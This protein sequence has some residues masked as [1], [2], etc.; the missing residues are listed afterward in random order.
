MAIM[1]SFAGAVFKVGIESYR[2]SGANAEIMRN[3]RAITDQLNADFQGLQKD[4]P[5]TIWFE[6]DPVS[7][8]RYDQIQ[9]FAD[10]DFQTTKL[11]DTDGDIVTPPDSIIYGNIAS[12]YYGHGWVVDSAMDA[13]KGYRVLDLNG[14]GT[15][16]AQSN[17]LARRIHISTNNASLVPFNNPDFNF[18]I[19]PTTNQYSSRFIPSFNN[20]Y[21]YDNYAT[22]AL[23]KQLLTVQANCDTYLETC[24]NNTYAPSPTAAV[25]GRPVIFMAQTAFIP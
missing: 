21:E 3:L 13:I 22:L 1:A 15:E 17:I 20:Y 11:Y 6:L 25:S 4:A 12:V 19:D 7:G 14:D 23:W 5:L 18:P 2:V 24:F 8:Q 10:G 16:E 9:F